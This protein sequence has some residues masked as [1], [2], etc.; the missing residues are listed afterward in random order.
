MKLQAARSMVPWILDERRTEIQVISALEQ[1]GRRFPGLQLDLGEGLALRV[2]VD[3][4]T[5]H[6]VQTQGL[7]DMGGM[8]THFETTYADHRRVGGVVFAMRETNFASGVET[9][10]TVIENVMLDPEITDGGFAPESQPL[11]S[12][13]AR[14]VRGLQ[15]GSARQ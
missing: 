6:V 1:E 3:P 14:S 7:L 9:G 5:H 2:Y 15:E 13:H 4:E 10:R 12:D 8:A 11:R